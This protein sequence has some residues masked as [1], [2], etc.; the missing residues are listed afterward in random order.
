MD[1]VEVDMVG[2]Q[3]A[4]T[5]LNAIHDVAA[6]GPDVIAA[7]ADAAVDLGRDHDVLS[8]DLEVLERLPEDL[9]ALTLGIDIRGIKEVDAAVNRCLD[10]L[11]GSGL[12]DR[13]DG[14]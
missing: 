12:T 10:E 4:Q 14:F 13:T 7:R 5:G 8:R 9:L 3:A 6:R 1:L 2:L 11:I